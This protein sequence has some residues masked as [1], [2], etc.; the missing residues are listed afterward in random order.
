LCAEAGR[1]DLGADALAEAH[2]LAIPDLDVMEMLTLDLARATRLMS[3]NR[4]EEAV[5]ALQVELA[6]V[7]KR[8]FELGDWY[9]NEALAEALAL[10][11]RGREAVRVWRAVETRR[12]NRCTRLTP[13]LLAR[14]ARIFRTV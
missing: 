13:R 9:A 2:A 14:R 10:A 12:L 6:E 7:A 8:E 1:D 3:M 5:D 4:P 11:G